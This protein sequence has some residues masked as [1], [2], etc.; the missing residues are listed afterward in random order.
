VR[1]VVRKPDGS[2]VD[3]VAVAAVA[4]AVVAAALLSRRGEVGGSSC[5]DKGC[6]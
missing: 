6:F 2:V 5:I 3:V 1:G 4:V